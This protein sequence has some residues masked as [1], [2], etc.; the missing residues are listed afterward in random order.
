M[1]KYFQYCR[2]YYQ[3]YVKGSLIVPEAASKK[4]TTY[5]GGYTHI[6]EEG[7]VWG[8]FLI[9]VASNRPLP[10][11]DAGQSMFVSEGIC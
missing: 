2:F 5:S 3:R 6:Q 10:D 4:M 7:T 9:C 8:R 11:L 1:L